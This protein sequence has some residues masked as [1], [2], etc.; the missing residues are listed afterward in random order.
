[1]KN[2]LVLFAHPF[3]EFSNNNRELINFYE[4][5]QHFTFRDLYEEYPDFHIPAFRE[6]KRIVNYDRIIFHFP[7]IWFGM[8]PL[9]RLWLDEV[10]DGNWLNPYS[11]NPLENTE[12]FI[13]VTT[14]SK[15]R[16]FGKNG[17]HGYSIEEMISGLLIS[18]K[19]FRAKIQ[20][21]Y[22]IYESDRLS[23]KEIIQHKQK[24][25]EILNQE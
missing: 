21:I 22:I 17:K 5:H 11:D 25:T 15:E 12:I 1:M 2:T 16:S 8:P 7:L 18:L 20:P 3:P 24:F 6:R 10:M 19:I 23:K 4:R 13:L 14:R 9:L